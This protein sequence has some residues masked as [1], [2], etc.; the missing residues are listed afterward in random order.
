VHTVE[1]GFIFFILT[2]APVS[3]PIII[4]FLLGVCSVVWKK[5]E[6]NFSKRERS[7]LMVL[8][9]LGTIGI[10]FLLIHIGAKFK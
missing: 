3:F 8:T 6:N 10:C 2:T 5:T 4:L 7:L 9:V 1:S